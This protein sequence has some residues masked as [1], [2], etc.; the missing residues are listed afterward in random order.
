[1]NAYHWVAFVFTILGILSLLAHWIK[2]W[3]TS[4][5]KS[6]LAPLERQ[7]KYLAVCLLDEQQKE[8]WETDGILT[9]QS[10]Y[11]V[12]TDEAKAWL[13][14]HGG[15]AVPK[16]FLDI[17]RELVDKEGLTESEFMD[18]LFMKLGEETIREGAYRRNMSISKWLAWWWTFVSQAKREGAAEVLAELGVY[19]VEQL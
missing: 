12:T 5:I 8:L 7:I 11:Q 17:F 10:P 18:A 4:Q 1:M 13:M 19:P 9:K 14:Q 16:H 2:K 15:L 6:S 3:I